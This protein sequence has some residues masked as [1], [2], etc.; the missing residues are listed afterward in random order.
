MST[1][2]GAWTTSACRA[3]NG[4]LHS[5]IF[6]HTTRAISNIIFRP[7]L[8]FRST[9]ANASLAVL[10]KI[11]EESLACTSC[12]LEVSW[13]RSDPRSRQYEQKSGWPAGLC[14]YC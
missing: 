6:V 5:Q 8:R 9:L 1:A 4:G 3:K 11:I 10:R 12:A 14:Y 13:T 2:G 7:A